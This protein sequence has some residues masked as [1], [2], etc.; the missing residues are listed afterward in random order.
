MRRWVLKGDPAV[1]AGCLL[2]VLIVVAVIVITTAL[3]LVV[4]VFV[5]V[6]KH[7]APLT[8]P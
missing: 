3:A 7:L 1:E 8:T 6:G 2:F 4:P 5:E